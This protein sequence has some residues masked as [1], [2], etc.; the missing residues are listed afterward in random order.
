MN[1]ARTRISLTL[2]ISTLLLA[3]ACGGGGDD[4]A[5]SLTSF[6]VDP[7]SV[8]VTGATGSC[9]SATV[10]MT[11]TIYGGTAPYR[12]DNAFP[13]L[14]AV[15]KSSV[16]DRGGKFTVSSV[17]AGCLDKGTIGVYDKNERLVKVTIT[18]AKGT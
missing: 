11:V 14:L 3:A 7:A 5:G 8:T 9:P 10:I 4:E 6:S 12:I 18:L 17:G 16:G 2:A 1:I 13:L 15:D